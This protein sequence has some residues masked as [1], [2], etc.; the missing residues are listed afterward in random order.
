M[1]FD[2]ADLMATLPS[3]KLPSPKLPSAMSLGPLSTR[4]LLTA[5]VYSVVASFPLFF[6]GGF[7]V[8]LQDDLSM[9]RSGFGLAIS[10]YFIASAFGSFTIGSLID[11][12]GAR[13]GFAFAATGGATASLLV[14]VS[15]SGQLF[16]LA[17]AV[18]GLSNTSGQ[19]GANRV[20]AGIGSARQGLAF[21]VKQAAVPMGSFLAGSVVGFMGSGI[22][23]RR[24]F[25]G[26][27]VFALLCATIAPDGPGRASALE[28]RQ[29]VGADR[30]C[31][32]AL[33]LAGA[34][35]G[36]TGNGL[37]VLTVDA[38]AQ[39]GYSETTSA[40]ALAVG[41]G[42]TIFARISV[43]WLAGRRNASGFVELASAKAL[44][45]AAF[46]LMA[47]GQGA[48]VLLWVG[49]F[50]AFLGAWGWPGV[51]YYAVT[52]N[53]RTTPGTATGFVVTGVF[54]GGIVGPPLLAW[55]AER[56]VYSAAWLAA[57]VMS[58]VATILVIVGSRLSLV[59]KDSVVAHPVG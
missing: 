42:M 9:S 24:A 30:P 45:A 34:L 55:I 40:S 35:G 32:L 14:A 51:M 23:W 12:Y 28:P 27:A 57:S 3:P 50:G 31:L 53:T 13:A 15:T 48:P 44:G 43:G 54:A 19:L 36:A 38:L 37:A 26:Y 2:G 52:R 5:V 47:V 11:S 46:G 39:S 56:W 8:R 17:L 41:S 7:A 1:H 16:A 58:V 59:R 6:A 10:A 22:D 33:A 4:P 25:L 49:L 21:G 18:A 20:L 29:P